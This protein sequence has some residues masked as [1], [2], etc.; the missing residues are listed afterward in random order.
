MSGPAF[1]FTFTYSVA[2][3]NDIP[4]QELALIVHAT[5]P[6]PDTIDEDSTGSSTEVI[7]LEKLPSLVISGLC[8]AVRLP[9]AYV[10]L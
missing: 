6:S 3:A 9:S 2:E 10:V 7:A 1:L 8:I 5:R 4:F